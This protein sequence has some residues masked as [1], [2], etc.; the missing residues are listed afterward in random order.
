MN[1]PSIR[2][3]IALVQQN[4]WTAWV[5]NWIGANV[6]P[7]QSV[8]MPAT[9]FVGPGAEGTIRLEHLG[10]SDGHVHLRAVMELSGDALTALL[11]GV[12]ED[13]KSSTGVDPGPMEVT[14]ASGRYE[15]EIVTDPA[16]LRPTRAV[17]GTEIR[18]VLRGHE[19]E[20]RQERHETTFDWAHA[21]GCGKPAKVAR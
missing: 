7:G 18:V 20:V 2:E 16:T 4:M 1:T 21:T 3:G 19:P 14:E 11:G 10:T 5:T 17:Y 8:E 12:F 6:S 9:E 15:Y 13:I